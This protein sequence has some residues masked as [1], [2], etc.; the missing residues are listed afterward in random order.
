MYELGRG[1]TRDLTKA[2]DYYRKSA[3]QGFAAAQ[4]NVGNMY[5]GGIGVAQDSME[6]VLWFRQAAD[7]G[8]AEAQYNLGLAYEIGRGVRTHAAQA[9]TWYRLAANQGYP[10]AQ[11]N[12][13]VMLEEGRGSAKDEVNAAKLYLAAARQGF[14]PAQNNLGIML[15]EGRGGLAV[16][17]VDALVWLSLATENGVSPEGRDIVTKQL[18]AAQLTEVG[19][20]LASIRAGASTPTQS[21]E[22]ANSG[23]SMSPANSTIATPEQLAPLLAEN[24]ELRAA[25]NQADRERLEMAARL[26]ELKAENE[27]LSAAI[28]N[29]SRVQTT[30]P[31]DLS[32]DERV[33][34]LLEDKGRRELRPG[35]ARQAFDHRAPAARSA[36]H[37]SSA[38]QQGPIAGRSGRCVVHPR[39]DI[40]RR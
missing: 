22:V 35:I 30:L 6:S 13:A 10:R 9:I 7:Q 12:L 5:A 33:K 27:R 21:S 28:A 16:N 2:F 36:L 32:T 24:E 18:S 38:A 26:Q 4:F 8:L 25:Q 14:G 17:P 3:T 20:R 19:K 34:R 31:A 15:A 29:A 1:V 39:S 23:P 11:Y 37:R 40:R